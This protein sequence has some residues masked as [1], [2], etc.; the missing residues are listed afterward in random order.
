MTTTASADTAA[1]SAAPSTDKSVLQRR[2]FLALGALALVFAFIAGLRTVGDPDLGWQM[3]TGRWIAQ[4]H[5]VFSTDVFSYTATGQ[6]WI[7]PAGSALLFYWTYLLGG[8]TL[9]SWLG[10]VV[11]VASVA[12]LLRRGSAF[13]AG[14]AILAVM[15]LAERTTPRAEMFTVVLFAA[16]LS[17]LWE[18]FRT[19]RAA[20]WLLPVL[21]IAWVNLH[22]GFIAGLALIAGFAGI[23]VLEMLSSAT[24]RSAAIQRL[25]RAAPWFVATLAATLVNPWGWGIYRAILRQ[26]RAMAEHSK[27]IVEWANA[28]WSWSGSLPSFSQQPVQHTFTLLVL[29]ALAGVVAAVLQRQWGASVLLLGAFYE[30]LRH[31]RLAAL[32]A[33]IVV[34]VAGGILAAAIPKLRAWIPNARVRSI[35]ATAAAILLAALAIVRSFEF[36]NSRIYLATDDLSTFGTGL[37]WWLPQGAA[38]FILR[39]KL[40][41]K[42]FNTY[43]EGGYLVWKL[44][45]EYQDYIDGRAIPFGPEALEREQA[46]LATPLDS[47]QWQEVA[48]RYGIRTL[49]I[50]FQRTEIAFS[51]LQDL[52]Y[53]NNWKPVYLDEL[54]IVLVRNQPETQDVLSR[55][56]INCAIAELPGGP[57]D[58]SARSFQRWVNTA[59]ILFVLHRKAE[60]LTAATHAVQIFPSSA[61]LR[62]VRGDILYDSHRH[63]EAEQEWLAAIALSHGDP[64]SDAAVWF[65]LGDLYEE[66]Q[67]IPEATRALQ[68]TVKLTPDPTTKSRT[69][70]RLARLYLLAGQSQA[71]LQA[72]DEAARAVPADMQEAGNGRSFRFDVAQGRAAAWRAAG[73][74]PKAISF[75]EEAVQL[76]PNA[77]D[78]WSHLAKLYQR[79][80]RVADARR[81]EEKA[82]SLGSQQAQ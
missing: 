21:M 45:P 52:C 30:S 72:L 63:E 2:L 36:L 62:Q 48:D 37:G 11:C 70:V 7:Y 76:D 79:A 33:C 15:F 64:I 38:D 56:Q 68:Q 34:V 1:Q 51:Q 14:L 10:A 6:P 49:I 31:I 24:R 77:A 19:G 57:L 80:G 27:A 3:A 69:L 47:P 20:L 73:N 55:T 75:A 46:L 81:A 60:A 41:G 26:N 32:A 67:R 61:R 53:S 66:Q 74:I 13:T 65:R 78:A 40:P 28:Q 23:E 25:R 12:L 4:H 43:N 8:Y 59:Q 16:Y 71:A 39:E 50:P 5:H 22:L 35:L 82:Q 44:G 42:V 29:I 54:A 58:T 17:I 18:N 9:L